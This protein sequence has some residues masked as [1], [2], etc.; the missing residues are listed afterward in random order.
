MEYRTT[1]HGSDTLKLT[2]TELLRLRDG[3]TLIAGAL[4]VSCS[5][6][7]PVQF[8]PCNECDRPHLCQIIKQGTQP[9]VHPDY[10]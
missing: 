1:P 3:E 10:R 6:V 4:H 2:D 9:C 7:P 5:F 8:E